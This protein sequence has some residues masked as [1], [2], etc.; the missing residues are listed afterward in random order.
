MEYALVY[1]HRRR[2]TPRP[3]EKAID[4]QTA[5]D[6]AILTGLGIGTAFALLALMIVMITS[7]KMFSDGVLD[8]LSERATERR[9]TMDAETRL[10]ALAAVAAVTSLRG[11]APISEPSEDADV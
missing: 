6:A 4:A 3:Q 2:E 7:V 9:A 5:E 10:K 11:N 1:N 8:R